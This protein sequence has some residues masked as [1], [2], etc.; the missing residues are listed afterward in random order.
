MDLLAFFDLCPKE[1]LGFDSHQLDPGQEFQS[2]LRLLLQIPHPAFVMHLQKLQEQK[3]KKLLDNF[4]YKTKNKISI[5]S[6]R[7]YY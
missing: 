5:I 1:Y 4:K 6:E 3:K 2:L 7:T